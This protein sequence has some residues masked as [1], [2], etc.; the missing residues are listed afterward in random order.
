MKYI[1]APRF[2]IPTLTSSSAEVFRNE[3]KSITPSIF[4]HFRNAK[5]IPP[6][7]TNSWGRDSHRGATPVRPHVTVRTLFGTAER[8]G[9]YLNSITGV[10]VATSLGVSSMAL[11]RGLFR[12]T[13]FTP[14]HQTELSTKDSLMYCSLHRVCQIIFKR[15]AHC[16]KYWKRFW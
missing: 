14:F 8:V 12:S 15:I 6:P 1:Q 3:F 16:E 13:F 9:L 4:D 2:E 11:L 5:K 10:P 7:R